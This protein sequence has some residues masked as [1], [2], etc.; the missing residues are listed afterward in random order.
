M[1]LYIDYRELNEVTIKNRHPL[2]KIDLCDQLQGSCIFS[3]VY[4]QLKIKL[5]DEAAF[6]T[7]YEHFE[8]LVMSFG[9]TNALAAFINLMNIVSQ[10]YFDQF[11]VMFI[12]D[13]LIYL[14]SKKKHEDYVKEILIVWG[15]NQEKIFQELK[16]N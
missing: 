11:V 4:Y 2:P 14:K 7:R 8:F 9:L 12:D 16:D 6:R 3:K 1:R 15:E 13:I 5:E 10:P